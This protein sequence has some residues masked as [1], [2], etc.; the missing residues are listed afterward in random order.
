MKV[1]L[2]E[3]SLNK[4]IVPD[5]SYEQNMMLR[6]QKWLG[7]DD[8]GQWVLERV[9]MERVSI[10]TYEMSHTYETVVTFYADIEGSLLVELLLRKPT[11]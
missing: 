3:F 5:G 8:F 6:W 11:T 9:P 1:V 10:K 7:T 4:S 2:C